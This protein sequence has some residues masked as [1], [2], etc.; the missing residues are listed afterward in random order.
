[1]KPGNREKLAQDIRSPRSAGLAGL[2]FAFLLIVQMVLGSTVGINSPVIRRD[3]LVE[4][5]RIAPLILGIVPFAGIAF[6]WFTGVIRDWLGERE[7]RF[8]SSIFF[9]SG[10]VYV[11]L[12]FVY[13]AVLGAT[14]GTYELTERFALDNDIVIF[15]FSLVNEILGNFALRMAGVY[16]FSI[17]SLLTRTGHAPRWLI[18]LTFVVATGFLLF[19]GTAGWARYFFPAWVIIISIYILVVNYRLENAPPTPMED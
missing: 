11:A 7:D 10:I 4:F 2:I 8:F 13:A 14:L 5:S 1:M 17:G 18:I 16:M 3:L 9:G 15:G 6:L 19:A 12:L